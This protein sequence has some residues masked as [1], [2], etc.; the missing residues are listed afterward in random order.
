MYIATHGSENVKFIVQRLEISY[1]NCSG[2]S[3]YII[4]ASFTVHFILLLHIDPEYGDCSESP[5]YGIAST[6]DAAKTKN[7]RVYLKHRWP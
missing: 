7:L 6:Y 2:I 4:F 5:N 3:V 1:W